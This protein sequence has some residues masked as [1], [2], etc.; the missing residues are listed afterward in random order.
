M[1]VKLILIN[2]WIFDNWKPFR[3]LELPCI[4]IFGPM[5]WEPQLR[6]D[7]G[8]TKCFCYLYSQTCH[9]KGRYE[10]LGSTPNSMPHGFG[11]MWDSRKSLFN[12]WMVSPHDIYPRHFL[13]L[14]SV[15]THPRQIYRSVIWFAIAF[16]GKHHWYRRWILSD[17][18]KPLLYLSVCTLG[19]LPLHFGPKSV[20]N[21]LTATFTSYDK[22]KISCH[23]LQREKCFLWIYKIHSISWRCCVPK[24]WQPG[25]TKHLGTNWKTK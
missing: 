25:C 14:F 13:V 8:I 1:Y 7:H 20:P 2:Y 4:A 16:T 17:G 21:I 15:H 24:E 5:L 9:G 10:I 12:N 3:I 22:I 18:H 6:W 23:T 11:L 19:P